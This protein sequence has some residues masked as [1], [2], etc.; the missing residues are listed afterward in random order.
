MQNREIE[1]KF[2]EIDKVALIKKLKELGAKDLG[3]NFLREMIFYD[4]AGKWIGEGKTFVRIREITP[5]LLIPLSPKRARR[6]RGGGYAAREEGQVRLTY[7]N[8]EAATA[9]GTE[10]IEFG[11]E[12]V[13]KAKNFLEKLGL[14]LHRDQEKKRHTFKL[15]KVAVEIDTWPKVPTYVELEGPLEQAIRQAAKKLGYNWKDAVFAN[16]R[17]VLERYYKIPVGKL[18]YL[19]FKKIG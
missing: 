19:T 3:E 11:I 5:S 15:G 9:I 18:K 12:S 16:S 14:V 7:K 13:T 6:G 2:L 10:E 4:A 1:A 17:M 8:L